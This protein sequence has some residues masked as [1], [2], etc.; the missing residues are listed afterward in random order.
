MHPPSTA[1]L[2]LL[3]QATAACDEATAELYLQ[4]EQVRRVS[5]QREQLLAYRHEYEAR[6]KTQFRT[7]AAIEVVQSYHGFVER[8]NQ[9]L[10]QLAQQATLAEHQEA[11]AR[12]RFVQRETRVASVKKLL[13]R[14]DGESLRA[15]A[16]LEQKASDDLAALKLWHARPASSATASH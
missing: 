8:L 7:S 2:T 5:S 9:A 6:W 3:E 13:Q 12:E 15:A 11:E 4:L 10:E 16:L 1:L 14:R